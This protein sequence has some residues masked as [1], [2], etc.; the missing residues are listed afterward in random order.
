MT[1]L[2]ITNPATGQAIAEVGLDNQL[3]LSQKFSDAQG[4]QRLWRKSS[5]GERVECALRFKSLLL[6]QIEILARD[7]T[8]ETG[9]PISQSR[10]EIRSVTSRIDFFVE[11]T[12]SILERQSVSASNSTVEEVIEHEPLG[13]VANISAWNYPYFVGLN[14]VIPA[15]LTGNAVVYK[16]S[17][18]ATLSGLH[19]VRLLKEAGFPSG[20]VAC[21][22]GT[23]EVGD[24]LLSLPLN[25][26]FF[27]GSQATGQKILQKV[28]SRMM[29]LQL[30]LGGK[31]GIYVCDDASLAH[32]VP[33]IAEGAFYNA[34]QGCCSVERVFIHDSIYE[35][36]KDA[37][38]KEVSSFKIGDPLD[39]ATFIGPLTRPQHVKFLL[40]QVDDARKHNDK[41]LLGGDKFPGGGSYFSPTVIECNK[42]NGRLMQEESF[43]PIVALQRVSGDDVA[44]A[45]LNDTDFG[46]TAGVYSKDKDRAVRILKEV[47]VGSAYWNCCDRVS[48]YLPWSG[49]KG[50]GIGATL[51][52]EG[53]RCF[54][55]S[56]SWH[57][58]PQP[59]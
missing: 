1:H 12:P 52:T 56:K 32:A 54:T 50:S 33:S 9:K 28:G 11:N 23:A 25:G 8:L 40:E 35:R 6:S 59:A 24:A 49:R 38:I 58:R 41:I 37:F 17:E 26:V 39:E 31:D 27:T 5:V 2:I 18:F 57:L 15:L 44:I 4:A 34:G 22:V 29:R 45:R 14:V 46:L 51:G 13:V 7:L 42:A 21:A 30:E 10:G 47:E 36:F 55:Q 43:G 3:S 19:I 53:I 20:L 48:P 16:P